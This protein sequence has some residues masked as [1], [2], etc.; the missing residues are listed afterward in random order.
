MLGRL[1]APTIVVVV[2]LVS[3][4][5]IRMDDPAA[6][7]SCSA[8]LAFPLESQTAFSTQK[9]VRRKAS[10]AVAAGVPQGSLLFLNKLHSHHDDDCSTRM[11]RA[12]RRFE[13]TLNLASSASSMTAGREQI[14]KRKK[15]D[16]ELLL[17]ARSYRRRIAGL[18]DEALLLYQQTTT[19]TTTTTEDETSCWIPAQVDS[20]LAHLAGRLRMVSSVMSKVQ[21]ISDG[22]ST[23]TEAA[24]SAQEAAL[25]VDEALLRPAPSEE[26]EALVRDFEMAVAAAGRTSKWTDWEALDRELA[27]VDQQLTAFQ[28]GASTTSASAKADATTKVDIP[29]PVEESTLGAAIIQDDEN[30]M[31]EETNDDDYDNAGTMDDV[32]DVAIVGA[33]L[34]GL[35]AGAILNTIYGKKVGV[36]ESHYLAGGCAHA[37]D[38]SAVTASGS[39]KTTFTFDSGPTILLGCSSPPFNGLQQVLEAIGQPV[40]WI[41]YNGWGMIENPGAGKGKELRWRVELGPTAFEEGPLRQFGGDLAVQEFK[42]LQEASKSLTAGVKIPAMAMRASKK[43]ALVPLLRYFPTLVDLIKEGDKLTGTFEPF[44]NGPIFKVTSPWLRDWLDALA[45]SL[46]GLPASRTAAAAMAFILNDMHREGAA[47]DYPKGG[48]GEIVEALVR[49]VEQGDNGSKVN[50]RQHVESIDCD[51][52][53]SS[54]KGITLRKSGNKVQAREGVICN[55]PVWSLRD[56]IKDERVLRKLN[57]NIPLLDRTIKGNEPPTS[58]TATYSGR[59]SIRLTRQQQDGEKEKNTGLLQ[60]CDTAE[61]TGSFIHL[62]LA[63]DANNLNLDELEAHYTVMDRSLSGDGSLPN[64]GP[65][66]ECNMIAVSNPCVLDRTLA[67]DGYILVHA[68]GAGNEP[69]ERWESL[70]RQSAE[71]Q[72]LKEERAVP[73]WRAVESIIP[74][75]RE[76]TVLQLIGSPLTH[77]RFLR[78]PRGTYGSATEDYL[79]DGSTPYRSLVLANDGVFPGIGVPSVAIA[80]AS[81]AN[82][83]VGVFEHWQTLGELEKKGKLMTTSA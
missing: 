62:H 52:S 11:P 73:L 60:K 10:A 8:V 59:A 46:S 38:R 61:M 42:A 78:R 37:F 23:T 51:H 14:D 76:R 80:G 68:Y 6:G 28:Q 50:L 83:L 3:I 40:E 49:G 9:F 30:A 33:G 15:I 25:A 64:D 71:Y 16:D 81:A 24:L 74:D 56:L 2:V 43:S 4:I 27:T 19:K 47:L 29:S 44:M 21:E 31:P 55:A 53:A 22:T 13:T 82:S 36:Y 69:Y 75:V 65:C 12:T 79:K 58:W 35:V 48:M 5:I 34:G 39:K 18:M 70:D 26:V 17:L 77:E 54:T 1:F 41:P 32:V 20:L 67:P 66:G 7:R 72:R 63:I 57:N 45:F